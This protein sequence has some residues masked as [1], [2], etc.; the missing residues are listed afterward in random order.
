MLESSTPD[1]K[2]SGT[3]KPLWSS[4]NLLDSV[5][6][7]ESSGPTKL[8]VSS[9][10]AVVVEESTQQNVAVNAFMDHQGRVRKRVQEMRLRSLSPSIVNRGEWDLYGLPIA[11]GQDYSKWFR[12][13]FVRKEKQLQETFVRE[14]RCERL[15]FSRLDFFSPEKTRFGREAGCCSGL[16]CSLF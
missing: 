8:R 4:G 14:V 6:K 9:A 3:R 10:D 13:E 1:Q 7:R 16:F 11:E 5:W 2:I 12:D 15:S